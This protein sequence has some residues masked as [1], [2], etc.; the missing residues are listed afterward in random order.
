MQQTQEEKGM[1]KN[2]IE[3]RQELRETWRKKL[4]QED[5]DENTKK[6]SDKL[7]LEERRIRT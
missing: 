5:C 1:M 7:G 2:S 4:I 6:T 3:E